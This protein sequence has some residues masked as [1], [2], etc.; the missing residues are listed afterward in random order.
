M[1]S[2]IGEVRLYH[3]T[4]NT[5]P[6]GVYDDITSQFTVGATSD[7]GSLVKGGLGPGT[8]YWF[9]VE[10]IDVAGNESAILPLGSITTTG[11]V[12][13]PADELPEKMQREL[14]QYVERFNEW[15]KLCNTMN[16]LDKIVKEDMILNK[17]DY[18]EDEGV[19]KTVNMLTVN[20]DDEKAKR[21]K[22]ARVE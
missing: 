5:I 19:E 14:A 3:N 15:K 17:I 13:I 1:A 4:A 7:T 21:A 9:W 2:G 16:R 18:I 6:V 8:K 11:D 22:R 20:V 12:P 10:V